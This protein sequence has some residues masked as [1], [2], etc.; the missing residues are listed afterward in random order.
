MSLSF[1]SPAK[2]KNLADT[3]IKKVDQ[4][5]VP[6]VVNKIKV[7]DNEKQLSAIF[8]SIPNKE[9]QTVIAPPKNY[10]PLS[11][12]QRKDWNAYLNYLEE[13]GLQGKAELDKG[14]PTKG[15]LVF[16]EYLKKNPN[17]SLNNYSNPEDLVKA[18]QYEMRI[19]RM[20]SSGFPQLNDSDLKILQEFL[21]LTRNKFMT[22]RTSDTD[23]NPG[24]YTT[25]CYYPEFSGS[26]D[27][28]K[29]ID[30]IKSTLVNR[31]KIEK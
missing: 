7:A 2:A 11:F 17:S 5:E 3:I 1:I 9:K 27:Y 6:T 15:R 4:K 22:T 14:V 19:I 18:I 26:V 28:S 13:E 24:Q 25:R 23:G 12:E 16:R 31:N 8:N 10:K 30:S 29:K 21:F 20:G